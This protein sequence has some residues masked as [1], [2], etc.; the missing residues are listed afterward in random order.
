MANCV[1]FQN[2]LNDQYQQIQYW[3]NEYLLA[4][5]GKPTDSGITDLSVISNFRTQAMNAYNNSAY[6]LVENCGY[7][8]TGTENGLLTIVPPNNSG[9]VLTEGFS[10]TGSTIVWIIMIILII[11]I[12]YGV[13]QYYKSH[14]VTT[15]TTVSSVPNKSGGNY[16]AFFSQLN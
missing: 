9:K 11:V 6:N 10:N 8:A 5:Q 7:Q 15:I 3:T 2:A 14:S 4:G 16:V 1:G 12:I 13:Y